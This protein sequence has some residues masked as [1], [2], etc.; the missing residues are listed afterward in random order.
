MPVSFTFQPGGVVVF[1]GSGGAGGHIT[2]AFSNA[3]CDVAFTYYKGQGPADAL[4][5][6]LRGAGRTVLCYQSDINIANDVAKI[7]DDAAEKFGSIHTVVYAAGPIIDV[8]PILENS[9]E[10]FKL[11]VDSELLGFFHIMRAAIRHLKASRGSVVACTSFANYK[12]LINDGLSASAK[13]GIESLIRQIAV[14]E[15][16]SGVR[17]NAIGLGWFDIGQGAVAPIAQSTTQSDIGK[18]MVK[19]MCS[20]IPLGN[21]PGRGEELASAAL[22]L[23]SEQ[24]SYI[25]GQTLL[26][27]GG[28]SL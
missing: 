2:R 21:R 1:G 7:I 18:D 6:E 20:M 4:A 26:V 3:G 15:G 12:V 14:E 22:F 25:T 17:A 28:I 5:K 10:R 19:L 23:A 9:P 8:C 13:A 27:D 24:A 11:Q 16:G